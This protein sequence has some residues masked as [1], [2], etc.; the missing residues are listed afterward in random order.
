MFLVWCERGVDGFRCDA[1]YM[2]PFPAWEYIIA[3]VREKYP[4]V[5]FLLEGLGGDPL[6]TLKLLNEGNMNWAYSELFQNYSKMAVEGYINYS[7]G[8]SASDGLMVHYA[9]THD[10]LR[11]AA[12]SHSYAK[13]RTALSAFTSSNGAFGF[14]NGVEW[15]AKEKID[16]HMAQGLN[17]GAK[18][19][20][21]EFISRLN[22]ILAA[23]PA[24]QTEGRIK[25]IDSGSSDVV[26]FIRGMADDVK[27]VLVIINLNSDQSSDLRLNINDL[28][29][30]L[31]KLYDLITK[32]E[33]KF[34]NSSLKL[35]P[36]EALCLS[37]DKKDITLVD[38][39]YSEEISPRTR[40]N[41]QK[42]RAMVLD[43]LC[44]KNSSN[45]VNNFDCRAAGLKLLNSPDK[46]LEDLF[47]SDEAIPVV[48]WK[49]PEDLNRTVLV[50]PNHLFIIESPYRFHAMITDEDDVVTP[51]ECLK[52]GPGKYFS[53][54]TPKSASKKH[55]YKYLNVRLSSQDGFKKETGKL[56]F[57]AEDFSNVKTLFDYEELRDSKHT[58]LATN[59]RGGILYPA[60]E[61]KELRSRYNCLLGANLS[62]EFPE[63]R[64]IMLRRFRAWVVYH[65][66]WQEISL[67]VTEEVF[68]NADGGVTWNFK[69][70]LSNGIFTRIA[71]SMNMVE[72]K[73]AIRVNVQRLDSEGEH[74]ALKNETPVKV[75]IR[76]DVE[77]RNF[78]MDTKASQGPENHWPYALETSV[79]SMTFKPADDRQLRIITNKGRFNE[80]HEWQYNIFLPNEASRGLEANGDLFSPGLFEIDLLGGQNAKI[81]AE[82]LTAWENDKL[83]V[84]PDVDTKQLMTPAASNVYNV[85]LTGMKDFV[86]KRN[87]LKT[88][89]AGYPWFLDWGRDTLICARGLISA[90]YT[91]D[92][93]MI[94]LQ[95]AK[96]AE[97]GT[98]PNIIHGDN[99][100]NR[101][102]SDAPLWLF[103][104]TSD[105]CKEMDDIN[106]IES[107]TGNGKTIKEVLISL[108]EGYLSGTP[109]N[110]SVDSETGLVY[111]PP[112]FTWMDTNYP[113]GTPREGYP[114]E[115]QAL[116]FF[117]LN[118]L[119]EVTGDKKWQALAEKV[120]KSILKYYLNDEGYLSD[121]L[122][123]SKGTAPKSAIKDDHL[124]PNQLFA[125]TLGAVKD[126]EIAKQILNATQSLLIP[127][128]IRSLADKPTEYPLP[129]YNGDNLLNNPNY[130]YWGNY[131]GDED[132][133]RKPAYHNGTAWS[134]PFPSY[135]E[136]YYSVYGE[137]GVKTARSILASSEIILN[138]GCIG[139]IPEILDGN[140]PHK[141]RGCDAQAWGITE[142]YRVWKLIH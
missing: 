65:G 62:T 46:F 119:F 18:E 63:D 102:T 69:V 1:G 51:I 15:F 47:S 68:K 27:P 44:W 59:G 45:V 130:P 86:V 99:V 78:H 137:F 76:P 110:I 88:V 67:N 20:Q 103:V 73:N 24:F 92:V 70:P 126:K 139:Q 19:N 31:G 7:D 104:A 54:V 2:I 98:L 3:R 118:F 66:R 136:A 25:F 35:K 5:I 16:V 38:K 107:D 133:R 11:L 50:P 22:C 131:S 49:Y 42:A 90:G 81:L 9:E 52:Q 129:I 109:N 41:E 28:P 120:Q 84:N 64:H 117:A 97:N 29:K 55:Q 80:N 127:G 135:V 21:V 34:T 141:E 106:F 30:S 125:V 4:D 128:A 8:V 112:H 93:K 87:S 124:R 140:A 142:L 14:A 40:I 10:N 17:W 56:L 43:V 13:M 39:V 57:L 77:D 108:A 71:I 100:G 33:I 60:L 105:L 53:V 48:R 134:W 91:D 26:A 12:T 111:S 23:L 74:K 123:C 95:F 132:T 72:G 114:I 32:K 75:L 61:W 89:I 96:F 83:D 37:W 82:V 94:L 85:L 101:D 36:G 113:A 122:H 116:W 121:C 6:I 79:K 138:E 58:F 115:I